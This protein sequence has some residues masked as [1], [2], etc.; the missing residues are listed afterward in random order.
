MPPNAKLSTSDSWLN[1]SVF[2][3][4]LRTC[5]LFYRALDFLYISLN[6]S[7]LELFSFCFLVAIVCTN[8]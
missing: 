2:M 6:V 7:V 5:S 8:T 4:S 3:V 1:D